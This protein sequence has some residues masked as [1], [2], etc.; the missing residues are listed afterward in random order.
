MMCCA[1]EES[2]LTNHQRS[3]FPT[4][5]QSQTSMARTKQSKENLEAND[6]TRFGNLP[7]SLGQKGEDFIQKTTLQELQR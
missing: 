1:P 5:R 4:P 6:L 3:T 7:T 2:L